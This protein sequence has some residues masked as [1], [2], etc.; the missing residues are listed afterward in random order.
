APNA[1][2]LPTCPPQDTYDVVIAGGGLGL[3]AGVALAARGLKVLV[4]DRDRVGAAHREWNISEREAQALV[5]SGLFTDEELASAVAARY[6]R[7][8]ISFGARGTGLPY[9]PL[10]LD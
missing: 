2:S 10:T 9:C 6:S 5:R 1:G 3:L 7:G 4:F 8:K